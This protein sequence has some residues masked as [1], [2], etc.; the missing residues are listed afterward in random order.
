MN[1]DEATANNQSRPAVWAP[2][3]PSVGPRAWLRVSNIGGQSRGVFETQD[4][5]LRSE[6]LDPLYDKAA[7]DAAVAAE[8]ERFRAALL[9]MH[10]R[11]KHR[12]NYWAFAANELCG[13]NAELR[14]RQRLHGD[15]EA[16]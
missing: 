2:V 7:L 12:H 11:D 6:R 1:D 16:N 3:E 10:E 14:G 5:E 9:A 15:A 13:P 8:R 4:V